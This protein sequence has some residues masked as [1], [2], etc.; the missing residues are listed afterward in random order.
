MFG[1]PGVRVLGAERDVGGVQTGWITARRR[2]NLASLL[3][4]TDDPDDRTSGRPVRRARQ[5][6]RLADRGPVT[7]QL[8]A[9]VLDL[10][11]RPDPVHRRQHSCLQLLRRHAAQSDHADAPAVSPTRPGVLE[12]RWRAPAQPHPAVPERCVVQY[13]L[14]P[15][16][17]HSQHTAT[18]AALDLTVGLDDQT[19]GPK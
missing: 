12:A 6:A 5:L 2:V 16:V 13:V 17:R 8:D 10:A 18:L 7:L 4:Q 1:V 9:V 15:A 11:T 14:P 3:V 19:G